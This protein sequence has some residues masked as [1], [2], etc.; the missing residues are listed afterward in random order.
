MPDACAGTLSMRCFVNTLTLRRADANPMLTGIGLASVITLI[1]TLAGLATTAIDGGEVWLTGTSWVLL[2]LVATGTFVGGLFI[3]RSVRA[4]SF[5]GVGAGA[6]A[7]SAV[8]S[9][10]ILAFAAKSTK[11]T[12]EVSAGVDKNAAVVQQLEAL[13]G[14]NQKKLADTNASIAA[15]KG[16]SALATAEQKQELA[17]LNTAQAK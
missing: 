11:K 16:A 14:T 8:L 5:G 12:V 13:L 7:G 1:I 17:N 9:V 3:P 15:L 6:L 10:L 4:P 2:A